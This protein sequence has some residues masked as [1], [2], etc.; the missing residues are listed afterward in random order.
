MAEKVVPMIH[1]PDVRATTDWYRDIG[2]AVM[3]TYGNGED[4]LSFAIISRGSSQLMF[5]QGGQPSTQFRREV[6]LYVYTDNVDHLY[7]ALKDKVVEQLYFT[8]FV[9]Q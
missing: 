3:N 8:E 9:V 7:Q 1:V 2:F 4:G 5:N 6:D